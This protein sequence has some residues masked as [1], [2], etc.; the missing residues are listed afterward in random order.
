MLPGLLPSRE[1]LDRIECQVSAQPKPTQVFPRLLD[2][3]AV[4]RVGAGTKDWIGS[5]LF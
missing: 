5:T 4:L 3:D 2:R 1:K